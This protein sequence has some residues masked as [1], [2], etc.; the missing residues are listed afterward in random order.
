MYFF[1]DIDIPTSTL[2]GVLTMMTVL[3][4]LVYLEEIVYLLSKTP[5]SYKRT[6][7]IW[8]TG[9]PPVSMGLIL[10]L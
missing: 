8:I 5:F 7:Y 2:Y 10:R 3:G 6:T 1:V 9:A 4:N